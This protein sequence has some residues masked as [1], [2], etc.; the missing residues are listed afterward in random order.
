MKKSKEDVVMELYISKV[1]RNGHN[2]LML[3]GYDHL[4]TAMDFMPLSTWVVPLF[5]SGSCGIWQ[6]I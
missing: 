3:A 2:D 1:I 6:P 4:G 5:V